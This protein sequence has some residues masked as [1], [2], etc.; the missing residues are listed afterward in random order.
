MGL[1][2]GGNDTFER[3]YRAKFQVLAAAH[4]LRIDYEQDLAALDQ[5]L[6]LVRSTPAGE[7]V[8]D[9]RIWFQFKGIMESTLSLSEFQAASSISISVAIEH[10]R[11]WYRSPEPV[12][13]V[14]YVQAADSF[15]A[16]DVKDFVDQRWGD[17]ILNEG[18]KNGQKTITLH[19]P[20]E[21]SVDNA[22]WQRLYRHRSM[23]ADGALYKGI[24]LPHRRDIQSEIL[25]KPDPALFQEVVR[26]LL[27]MH[28]Y[29]AQEEVDPSTLFPNG[30]SRG[31]SVSLT[32]GRL[33]NAYEWF[34][35]L[36]AEVMHD[37]NG[38]RFEGQAFRVQGPCAVLVHSAVVSTPD[39]DALREFCEQLSQRGIKDLL[40]FVNS[41]NVT[42]PGE[43]RY[44]GLAY[45]LQAAGPTGVR[46]IP[47]NLEDISRNV[48]INP[49]VYTQFRDRLTWWSD[50][51]RDKIEAGEW[52]IIPPQ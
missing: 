3:G 5:G 4:G 43:K 10:L 46:C 47:Q 33:F 1:T 31:D 27:H 8:T 11:Q 41:Y 35:Y 38:Y 48:L 44:D 42:M 22:F 34:P 14:V 49:I 19:I 18:F 13:L 2:V 21:S 51:T 25:Y 7:R 26:S 23:R 29:V 36:T 6:H 37:E 15:Y 45:Y 32:I 17:R 30:Q 39:S 16:I 9:T 28:G 52:R 20:K 40:V 12:Y 50:Y 24:P